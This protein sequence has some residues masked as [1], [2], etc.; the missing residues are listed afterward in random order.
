MPPKKYLIHLPVATARERLSLHM[1]L[2]KDVADERNQVRER[3][4]RHPSKK[5]LTKHQVC[6]DGVDRSQQAEKIRQL[7]I[8]SDESRCGAPEAN[9]ER[10]KKIAFVVIVDPTGNQNSA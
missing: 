2:C 8:K 6:M 7:K 4:R 3:E 1:A 9:E 5:A 10:Q